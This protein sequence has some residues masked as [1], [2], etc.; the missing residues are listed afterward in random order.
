M[1][2][3]RYRGV[4]SIT[5]RTN[6]RDLHGMLLEVAVEQARFAHLGPASACVPYH[7]RMRSASLVSGSCLRPAGS[8]ARSAALP[9]RAPR[10]DA[11]P[12]RWGS[13]RRTASAYPTASAA[14]LARAFARR[15][16]AAAAAAALAMQQTTEPSYRCWSHFSQATKCSQTSP[17]HPASICRC[18]CESDDHA[19]CR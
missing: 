9:Q 11:P 2:H 19:Q 4:S 7:E 5:F 3:N 10:L 1:S 14:A 17:P 18:G 12:P 15:P 8:S 13:N 16:A 6:P